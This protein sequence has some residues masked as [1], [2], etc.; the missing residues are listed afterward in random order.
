MRNT[1][2][3]AAKWKRRLIWPLIST[4][5]LCLIP[6][7]GCSS[8]AK[9]K[10]LVFCPPAILLDDLKIPSRQGIKTV[11]DMARLILSDERA[12]RQK[13]A[14]LQALREYRANLLKEAARDD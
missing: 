6:C 11:G 12:M 5:C 9:P 14:D 10:T 1:P 4:M 2:K 3:N 13:N 7:S 8:A